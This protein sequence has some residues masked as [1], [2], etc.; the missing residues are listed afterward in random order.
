MVPPLAVVTG[1]NVGIGACR[2][3]ADECAR[4]A[5]TSKRA[6]RPPAAAAR[7]TLHLAARPP[8]AGLEVTAGLRQHGH[9][10]IMACRSEERCQAAKAELDGRG[11][12]GSCECRRVDVSDYASIRRFAQEL[13]ERPP[14]PAGAAAAAGAGAAP[15]QFDL[16][17]NNAGVMGAFEDHMTPNHFGPYLLTRLLLPMM[18]PGSRLVSVA[19]EAHRRGSLRVGRQPG[20]PALRCLDGE[21]PGNW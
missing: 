11:L 4:A 13:R 15:P 7:R 10:V 9:H 2:E 21:P 3:A 6:A 12:P 20:D 18:A 8:P 14:R 17:V 19:S 1:A 16:V 5:G